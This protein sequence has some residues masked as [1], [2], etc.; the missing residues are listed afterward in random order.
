MSVP[1]RV[2]I[3]TDSFPPRCG[4]SGWSTWELVRGLIARGHHVDVIKLEAGSG[5]DA[6]FES[7]YESVRVTTYRKNAP[8]LPVVRNIV[9][10]ERL[11]SVVTREVLAKRLA[12]DP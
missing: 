2:L 10:N 5:E 3:V 8:Q 1:L 7:K 12:T 9:K 4:G 11:W 6:I